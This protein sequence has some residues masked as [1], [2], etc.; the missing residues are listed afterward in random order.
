MDK[1]L[2]IAGMYRNLAQIGEF[3][4]RWAKKAGLDERAVYAVQ[5]AVDEACSNIIEHAYGGENR[6]EIELCCQ[7]LPDGLKITITDWG[8]PFD[9]QAV[10]EPNIHAPLEERGEGGLGLFLMKQLMDEVS[11]EFGRRRNTLVLV[12]KQE[13]PV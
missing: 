9:P 4:T 3:V 13:T 6:G 2:T 12:K 10:Q 11:F 8:E 1:V 5:M 7:P